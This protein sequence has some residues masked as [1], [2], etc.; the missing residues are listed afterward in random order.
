MS[1]YDFNKA[2]KQLCM[3]DS[4]AREKHWLVTNWPPR[5]GLKPG[6]ANILHEPLV[7]RKKIIFSPLRIKLCLVKQ[8][9]KA[10]STDGD[11]F[12]YIILQFSGLPI[13]KI[14]SGVFDGSQIW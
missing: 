10:L 6:D 11:C 8:F 5:S 9:V 13:E 4:R 2:A 14:K 1:K 3:W 7:E 12:K